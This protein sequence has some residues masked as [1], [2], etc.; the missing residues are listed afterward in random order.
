MLAYAQNFP[1]GLSAGPLA[2]RLGAPL[3]LAQNS[4]RAAD[5][6]KSYVDLYI[7]TL[8]ELYVLGGNTLIA[9]C[10]AASIYYAGRA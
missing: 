2:S 8:K 6:I 9:N 3:V 7:P 4:T 10:Y 5:V 1:D